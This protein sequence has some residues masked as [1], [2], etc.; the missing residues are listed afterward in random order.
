M[1]LMMFIATVLNLISVGLNLYSYRRYTKLTDN[2]INDFS[3][4]EYYKDV[5]IH[6]C[7]PGETTKHVKTAWLAMNDNNEYIWTISNSDQ[8]IPDDWVIKWEYIK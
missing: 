2:I 7:I 8:V 1:E 3:H 6:Y 4:P 5:Q